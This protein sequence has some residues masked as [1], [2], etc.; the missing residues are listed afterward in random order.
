[1]SEEKLESIEKLL[2]IIANS[3]N[4]TNET[5]ISIRRDLVEIM[6]VLREKLG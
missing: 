3:L 4:D 5:I 2:E 1:M 6:E